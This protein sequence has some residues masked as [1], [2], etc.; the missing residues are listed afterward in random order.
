MV[1]FFLGVFSI[2]IIVLVTW[3]F[4]KWKQG[5]IERQKQLNELQLKAIRSKALPHFTGNSFANIDF[6]IEKGDTENASRYLAIL[7]RLHNITLADSDKPSRSIE[8]EIDYVKLYLQMEKLRFEHKLEY[9]IEVDPSIDQEQQVP[10]MVLH[11]YAENALKHG[12]KHKEGNG[13]IIVK[14]VNQS[15]GVLL[16][17]TDNG[18]GREAAARMKSFGTQQGL[19]ILGKQIELYNQ[20][21]KEKMVQ[22]V[23]D[24]L[25]EEGRV[26][27]TRF[28]IF[29]PSNFKY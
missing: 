18:I 15:G 14:A 4:S 20:Q 5:S 25:D 10:N 26:V 7:S 8:E 12:L 21:N 22:E 11:T 1:L 24:M 27:G 6:Y 19:A 17:V 29:I 3:T 9:I 28:A 13:L 23:V 2:S 16:S